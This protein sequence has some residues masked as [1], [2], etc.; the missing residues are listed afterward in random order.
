MKKLVATLACRNQGTRLYGKPL[1]N[2]DIKNKIT[3]L[4]HQI[5]LIRTIPP[6]Q[7]IVL[8]IS[9]GSDNSVYYEFAKKNKIKSITG[10]QEDVLE[11]LI[12]CLEEV[13][14]T[15]A[16][17]I[18]T[19]SP[20]IFYDAIEDSWEQHKKNRLDF[21][22]LDNV[23]DGCGFEMISLDA[24]K[25]SHKKGLPKHRSELCSLYI[26]EN[27]ADFKTRYIEVPD[28]LRRLD[29]RLTVDYPEDLILCRTIYQKF[30]QLA[31]RIPLQ[32]VIDFLDQNPRLK[33]LVEPLIDE[34]LK[35]MNI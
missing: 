27:K 3:I 24:L 7:E 35:T 6:I 10:D 29:I 22:Y 4:Q 17:R 18:T 14:G 16:F 32:N 13:D 23:P 9:E 30:S 1:Q 5:D 34:G 31:P 20:F 2:L 21:S 12:L 11:R 15:D 26:R 28:M 8:G 33:D 25:I 19:E